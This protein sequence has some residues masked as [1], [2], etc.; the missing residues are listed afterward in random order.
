MA[1]INRSPEVQKTTT[2][3][4]TVGSQLKSLRHTLE[5]LG[6]FN[7]IALEMTILLGPTRKLNEGIIIA[8][9]G[10]ILFFAIPDLIRYLNYY[11]V[12]K[13]ITVTVKDEE[14]HLTVESEHGHRDYSFDQVKEITR[15]TPEVVGRR[16]NPKPRWGDFFY[17]DIT[18]TTGEEILIT[19]LMTYEGE[20]QVGEKKSELSAWGYVA[21][22]SSKGSRIVNLELKRSKEGVSAG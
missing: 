8:N 9:A 6:G 22:I 5:I 4:M 11:R 17:Y 7:I 16:R 12:S 13:G 10:I 20:L 18:L 2:F 21:W 14:R 19:S 3:R 1:R 15:V